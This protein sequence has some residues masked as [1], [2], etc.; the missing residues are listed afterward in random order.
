MITGFGV[1]KGFAHFHRTAADLTTDASDYY[2]SPTC[3][4]TQI[5]CVELLLTRKEGEE[6]ARADAEERTKK[7]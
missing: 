3:C 7:T 4:P 2:I 6:M 1:N 5:E